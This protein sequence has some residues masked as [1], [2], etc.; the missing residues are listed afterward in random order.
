MALV[1]DPA[2]GAAQAWVINETIQP[3]SVPVPSGAVGAVSYRWE[4]LPPGVEFNEDTLVVFGAPSEAGAG[5]FVLEATDDDGVVEWPIVWSVAGFVSQLEVGAFEDLRVLIGQPVDYRLP[6]PVGGTPPYSWSIVDPVYSRVELGR[7]WPYDP[8]L[9]QGITFTDGLFSGTASDTLDNRGEIWYNQ[10]GTVDRRTQGNPVNRLFPQWYPPAGIEN[11]FFDYETSRY[12]IEVVLSRTRPTDGVAYGPDAPPGGLRFRASSPSGHGRLDNRNVGTV[13]HCNPFIRITSVQNPSRQAYFYFAGV[14]N[15]PSA[16]WQW[17][18]SPSYPAVAPYLD[19]EANTGT[20]FR[21][22]IGT[23]Q[24]Y[25]ITIRVSDSVGSAVEQTIMVRVASVPAGAPFQPVIMTAEVTAHTADVTLGTAPPGAVSEYA[26]EQGGDQPVRWTPFVGDRLIIPQLSPA[27]SYNLWIRYRNQAGAGP[28][29]FLDVQTLSAAGIVQAPAPTGLSLDNNPGDRRGILD[30]KLRARWDV[31]DITTQV[32]GY[33]YQI[34]PSGQPLH[35]DRW[36]AMPASTSATSVFTWQGLRNGQ[37]YRLGVRARNDAGAGRVAEI[38]GTPVEGRPDTDYSRWQVQIMMDLTGRGDDPRGAPWFD[39]AS[40]CLEIYV[41]GGRAARQQLTSTGTCAFLL[42]TSDDFINVEG[43]SLYRLDDL[44][45]RIVHINEVLELP[46]GLRRRTRFAGLVETARFTTSGLR[47]VIEVVAVDFFGMMAQDSATFALDLPAQTTGDRIRLLLDTAGW[48]ADS[49]ELRSYNPELIDEGSK[50]CARIPVSEGIPQTF[51]LLDEINLTTQS[52]GGRVY[53][54]GG[55]DNRP[56]LI[57]FDGASPVTTFDGRVS[58]QRINDPAVLQMGGQPTIESEDSFLYNDFALEYPGG[59]QP[60]RIPPN[61]ASVAIWGKRTY[62]LYTEVRTDQEST[63]ALL[64]ALK[65]QYGTPRRWISEL[66]L[67]AHF[68][69]NTAARL[70]QDLD[71]SKSLLV[72]YRPPGAREEITAIQRVDS[73]QISYRPLDRQYVSIDWKL[74][75]LI[76]EAS[77]YW[78]VDVEGADRLDVLGS[79]ETV[80]APRRNLDPPLGAPAGRLPGGFRRTPDRE[81]QVVSANRFDGYLSQQA[82]PVYTSEEERDRFEGDPGT[83]TGPRDGHSCVVIETSAAGVKAYWLYE[84]SGESFQW[85]RRAQ[86]TQA[87]A[88]PTTMLFLLGDKDRGILGLA[89]GNVLDVGT[90][91]ANLRA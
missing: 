82:H 21:L 66:P 42:E 58:D 28:A 76:P 22:E 24:V 47:S 12:D 90:L 50:I 65:R 81:F 10:V 20:E 62:D 13:P 23:S 74:G 6:V 31:A 63:Q 9:P 84:Y 37:E 18:F 41:Q 75:L 91:A 4:G 33:D 26:F 79:P 7:G 48:A 55:G 87:D 46:G 68:Q 83:D 29:V 43:T 5:R 49:D 34:V 70:I 59:D 3:V 11:R 73:Y 14:T 51:N 1:F 27:T 15:T 61:A 85:L 64:R 52:E 17:F 89:A 56:G 30:G 78:I 39:L 57:R 77:A 8:R 88:N 60:E 16:A 36:R 38:V 40:R 72:D 35:P 54:A 80:L 2:E 25:P 67:A 44:Q 71:L 32:L 45:N 69:T 86:L 53:I 19:T